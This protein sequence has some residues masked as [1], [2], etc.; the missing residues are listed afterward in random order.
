MPSECGKFGSLI[1]L[2]FWVRET[3]AGLL[4]HSIH[5]MSI[6]LSSSAGV[7]NLIVSVCELCAPKS[8]L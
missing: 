1:G 7:K 2:R 8:E 3:G 5:K 6:K 4:G